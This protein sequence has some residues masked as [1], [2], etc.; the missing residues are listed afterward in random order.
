MSYVNN[1]QPD[2]AIVDANVALS[3]DPQNVKA[4]LALGRAVYLTGD[5]IKALS[6]CEEGLAIDGKNEVQI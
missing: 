3:L 6:V 2:L 5:A 1:E 4:L